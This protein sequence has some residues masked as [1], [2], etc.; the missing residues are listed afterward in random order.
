M[1]KHILYG[2]IISNVLKHERREI[3]VNNK[4][5]HHHIDVMIN[6]TTATDIDNTECPYKD[7]KPRFRTV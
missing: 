6:H 4:H 7:I 2:S 5:H 3:K 1:S